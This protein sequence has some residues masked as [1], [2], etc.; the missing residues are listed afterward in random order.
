M[1]V[2]IEELLGKKHKISAT[3]S[4]IEQLFVK[5]KLLCFGRY[6]LTV[7]EEAILVWGSDYMDCFPNRAKDIKE[8]M[9]AKRADILKKDKTAVINYFGPGPAP[10][11]GWIRSYADEFSPKYG[12]EGFQ[13]YHV[14]DPHIFRWQTGTAAS[15]NSTVGSITKET[16]FIAANLRARETNEAPTEPGLCLEYGFLRN[17]PY[18]EQEYFSTG[19][20]IP[21]LDDVTFSVESNQNASTKGSNGYSL[22]KKINDRRKE[23]GSD[24][25]KLTTLREGMRDVHGWSGEESL[26]R[27]ADST[28]DFEWMFVGETGNVAH[29]ANIDVTMYTKVKANRIG[30]A[31]ASSLNDEETIALWDKLLEGLKFRVA[32]PGAPSDAVELK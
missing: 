19:L 16:Q 14:V 18:G 8:I 22:L 9:E 5:P 31:T 2:F 1:S 25:P 17:S 32:V 27:R 10:N 24:Y 12:L 21:S 15:V 30:A 28:H 3:D 23:L 29:P 13:I 11:A 20:H 7:P 26:V 4:R 6:V